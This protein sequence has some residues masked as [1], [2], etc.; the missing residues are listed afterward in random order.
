MKIE[1]T[2]TSHHLEEQLRAAAPALPL[3]LR[4]RTLTRCAAQVQS[5]Q[6]RRQRGSKRLVWSL[7]GL[8]VFQWLVV[9]LLD[10]QH[11]ALLT[12]TANQAQPRPVHVS[13]AKTSSVDLWTTVQ[14]RSQTLAHLMAN[15]SDWIA[16]PEAG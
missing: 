7:T 5:E 10:S 1:Q 6:R 4:T 15:R 9:S 14:A 3:A 2:D 12:T 13:I 8:C 16:S 11:T